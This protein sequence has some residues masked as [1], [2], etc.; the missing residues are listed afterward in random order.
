[1]A[2]P[3]PLSALL[4]RLGAMGVPRRTALATVARTAASVLAALLQVHSEHPCSQ[5]QHD[6]QQDDALQVHRMR[7]MMNAT[8]QATTHWKPITKSI[9]RVPSSRRMVD[10]AAMQ[11]V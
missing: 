8:T 4:V 1:M 2:P 9:Q 3:L 7:F 5:C 10:M 11:G 6:G